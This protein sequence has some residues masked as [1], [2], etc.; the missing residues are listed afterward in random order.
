VADGRPAI[1]AAMRREVLVEAGHRCAIPTCRSYPVDIAHIDPWSK[2]QTHEAHNLIVLCA[3]CHRR[4][5]NGDID[6]QSMLAYKANLATIHSRYGDLEERVLESM[7]ADQMTA[8]TTI[9]LPGQL[10]ILMDRLVRDGIVERQILPNELWFAKGNV[11]HP[12]FHG[13]IVTEAGERLAANL[14]SARPIE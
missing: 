14:R 4:Y 12:M 5:D 13:Y 2:V 10:T 8:G 11:R 1:P 6:R 3:N 7:V 9:L